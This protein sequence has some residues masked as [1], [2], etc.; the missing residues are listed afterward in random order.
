MRSPYSFLA[1]LG[2]AALLTACG[3]SAPGDA[4]PAGPEAAPESAEVS[5]MAACPEIGYCRVRTSS[6]RCS[7]GFLVYARPSDDG[8]CIEQNACARHGG[9]VICG[10]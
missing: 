4:A 6:I 2:A 7:N 5:A 8:W 1:S 3:G 9:P 10:D